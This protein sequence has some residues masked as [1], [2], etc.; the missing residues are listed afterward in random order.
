MSTWKG[1]GGYLS[2][3]IAVI[4]G[5]T[6][7][8]RSFEDYYKITTGLAASFKF[9][10]G[11]DE[12]STLCLFAPNHVDYLP[13]TVAVGLCGAK[14]APVN[15]LYKANELEIILDKSHSSILV[16]HVNTLEVALEAA[17]NSRYVKH[18]VVMTQDTKD[19]S[20]PEGV[21][22]LNSIKDHLRAIF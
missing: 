9:E 10:L 14:I 7:M 1:S 13:V 8:Q 21:I 22:D 18:V 20:T 15:P 2:T 6:G 12:A 4:D 19:S 11:L 5:S 17:K 16:A 3:E